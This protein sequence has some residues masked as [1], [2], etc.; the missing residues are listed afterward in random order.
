[1][2]QNEAYVTI[3]KFLY[4]L[5][6]PP[7]PHTDGYITKRLIDMSNTLLNKLIRPWKVMGN[8]NIAWLTIMTNL[9]TN[10]KSVSV[11]NPTC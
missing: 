11:N 5:K 4:K 6:I 1:M 2:K 10:N 7:S 3:S 9:L 8:Y